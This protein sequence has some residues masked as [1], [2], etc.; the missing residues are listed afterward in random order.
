[1]QTQKITYIVLLALASFFVLDFFIRQVFSARS[2]NK[3]QEKEQVKKDTLK[4]SRVADSIAANYGPAGFRENQKKNSRVASAYKEKG[5]TLMK[6]YDK[7]N[8]D[9]STIQIY[10]RAFKKEKLLEVWAKDQKKEAFTLIRTYS[11][12]AT[13][14]TLGPKR[15]NGDEQIPEG[16]Y[17]IDRF[18]PK[19]KFHLSLGLNY[20]NK[21][22]K[23]LGDTLQLGSDIFIHGGCATIGCIP[24]T[25]AKIK[26]LYLM[27]TDAKAAGQGKIPVTIFPAKLHKEGFEKL[28]A[29]Y[30]DQTKLLRFW[31]SLQDGYLF[32]EKCKKLPTIAYTTDG[33]YKCTSGCN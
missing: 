9:P 10:I 17:H 4:K 26:E 25:D 5:D 13:S 3:K 11:F 27:A 2:K 18:N 1:M 19:S 33:Y 6:I 31:K 14:G 28:K 8:I 30:A 24:I 7:F 16:F 23:Q 22:D 12:C 15:K 29:D 20:P 21:L 32:F